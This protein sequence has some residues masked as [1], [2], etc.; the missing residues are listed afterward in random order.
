MA[1]GIGLDGAEICLAI[2]MG[3]EGTADAEPHLY[4][5]IGFDGADN[6]KI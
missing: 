3:S 5:M 2:R 4:I 1:I 6:T